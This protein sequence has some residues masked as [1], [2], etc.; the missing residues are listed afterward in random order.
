MSLE[1]RIYSILVVSASEN[2]NSTL[3]SLLPE[4]R[5]SPV[6]TVTSI[7]AAKRSALDREFDFIL[8]HIHACD[9]MS[10]LCKAYPRNEAYITCT[11]YCYIHCC[12]YLLCTNIRCSVLRF[13]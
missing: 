8:I 1:K 9:R 11:C 12:S 6:R 10:D 3:L 13:P 2:F 7:N 4:A 5:Y